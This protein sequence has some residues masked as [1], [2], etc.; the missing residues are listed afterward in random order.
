M[1]L[2]EFELLP[3]RETD[4]DAA[5]AI[6]QCAH[7][8]PWTRGNFDDSFKAGHSAWVLR[9]GNV[10][11]GYGLLMMSGDD[12]DLLNITIAPEAQRRG[13]GLLLLD[14]LFTVA[15]RHGATRMILEVRQGNDAALALYRHAG[16]AEIGR[17][18]AYYQG[19]EDAIVMAHEL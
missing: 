2:P 15:R 19:K 14:H 4:L 7:R 6:E 9:E 17:R 3:M 16:F 10:L 1:S 5:A 18:R 8:F 12:A 13:W 11:I